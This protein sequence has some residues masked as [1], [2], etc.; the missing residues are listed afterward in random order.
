MAQTAARAA[1]AAGAVRA[2]GE[3]LEDR[4]HRRAPYGRA[5]GL[6]AADLRGARRAGFMKNPVVYR[7]VQ[8]GGGGGRLNP[9]APL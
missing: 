9:L 5:A 7:A 3:G 2:R 6:D 1:G 8:D 4:R